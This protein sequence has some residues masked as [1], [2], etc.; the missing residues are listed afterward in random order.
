MRLEKCGSG[1]TV[2]AFNRSTERVEDFVKGRAAGKS[3]RGLHSPVESLAS[4]RKIMPM[5]RAGQPVDVFSKVD[6][7][8][9][10]FVPV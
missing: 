8:R 9:L 10:A 4:P 7:W 5:V 1:Y 3:I 2:T 6:I